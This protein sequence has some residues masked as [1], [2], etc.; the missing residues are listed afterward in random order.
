MVSG[1][2]LDSSCTYFFNVTSIFALMSGKVCLMWCRRIEFNFL[3]KYGVPQY[4]AL[5]L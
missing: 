4:C 2:K 3:A 1:P 5:E